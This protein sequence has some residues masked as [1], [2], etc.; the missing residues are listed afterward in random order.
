MA[1]SAGARSANTSPLRSSSTG[2]PPG[3]KTASFAT[4]GQTV[5]KQRDQE[6]PKTRT[7]AYS[8]ASTAASS[9]GGLSQIDR[10]YGF[11]GICLSLDL[12]SM[13]EQESKGLAKGKERWPFRPAPHPPGPLLPPP[14]PRPGEEGGLSA[15]CSV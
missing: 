2:A 12:H 13:A 5:K 9:R 3:W 15:G 4:F 14:S 8:T 11:Q 6:K 10:Q 7:V 1:R